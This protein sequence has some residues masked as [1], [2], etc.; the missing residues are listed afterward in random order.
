MKLLQDALTEAHV[1][2]E[3]I[4]LTFL[5]IFHPI[6]ACT[7]YKPSFPQLS[8]RWKYVVL[9]DLNRRVLVLHGHGMELRPRVVMTFCQMLVILQEIWGISC[10]YSGF[11]HLKIIW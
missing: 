3:G 4:S 10:S 5:L 6:A 1:C 7:Q 9:I 2:P 11:F 8:H